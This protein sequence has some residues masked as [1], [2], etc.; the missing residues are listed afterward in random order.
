MSGLVQYF[1]FCLED[2]SEFGRFHKK[3]TMEIVFRCIPVET[4]R[5]PLISLYVQLVCI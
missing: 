1:L 4:L 3:I 2:V 5:I